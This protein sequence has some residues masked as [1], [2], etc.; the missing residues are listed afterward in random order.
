MTTVISYLVTIL[1]SEARDNTIIETSATQQVRPF[2]VKFLQNKI[3]IWSAWSNASTNRKIFA[4]TLTVSS[5]TLVVKF[6]TMGK[7]LAIAHQFG[8]GEVLDAFMIAYILPSMAINVLAGSFNSAMMPTFIEVSDNKDHKA[9]QQLFSSVLTL[10]IVFLSLCS[11]ILAV[12]APVVLPILGSGFEPT[13]LA[14]TQS[15]FYWLLPVIVLQGVALLYATVINAKERFALV[16][17]TPIITP[18]FTIVLI[19]F[20]SQTRWDIYALVG[21]MVLGSVLELLFLSRILSRQGIIVTPKWF[22]MTPE[23]HQVVRQYSPMVAGAFLMS[24][25][26]LVDQAMAAMLEPGSVA[27]LGYANKLVSL[28]L[29][30]GALALGTAV[31]PHFSRMVAQKDWTALRHTVT[32]YTYLI[33]WVTVPLAAI[34]FFFSEFIVGLL[35]ERG[36]FTH[37]D[38]VLVGQIQA[39]YVLQVPFYV[40]GLLMARII[41]SLKKN[42]LLMWGACISLL[43]NIIFNFVF[44]QW[45]GI[46]GIALSTAIVY[47]S[48]FAFLSFG[49]RKSIEKLS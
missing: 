17:L 6:V 28:I 26:V 9:A 39:F 14:L 22:G 46:A 5:L 18:L 2:M 49:F 25:T 29:G 3:T 27:A 19:L 12:L 16:A 38:T 37:E 42:Y 41:S 33:V 10:G 4:A 47:F 35:F 43:L 24:S 15:L 8:V 40:L 11:I 1:I 31:L 23:L 20:L 36:A 45:I 34:L 13:T 30:L 32:K 21:G 48:S 7:E 44:M